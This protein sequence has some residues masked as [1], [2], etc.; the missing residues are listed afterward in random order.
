M[1]RAGYVIVSRPDKTDDSE[2][3][4]LKLDAASYV[5]GDNSVHLRM[6]EG[7]AVDVKSDE[8]V[9]LADLSLLSDT[10][11]TEQQPWASYRVVAF[12]ELN[13]QLAKCYSVVLSLAKKMIFL[14]CGQVSIG[15]SEMLDMHS[16]FVNIYT[17]TH[18]TN[19]L[20]LD[21]HDADYQKFHA[22]NEI[23]Y[24]LNINQPLNI[25]AET[26]RIY[27]AIVA[28]KISGFVL[29]P[30]DE[31]NQWKFNNYLFEVT[32]PQ[33]A[34]GYV[35]FISCPDD[36]YVI[37]QK[38][39]AKDALERI[40]LRTKGVRLNGKTM[41]EVLHERF[42][43]YTFIAHSPFSR[44]RYDVNIESLETGNIYSIM[45]DHCRL[46]DDVTYELRQ[47]EIEYLKSRSVL[48]LHDVNEEL[49]KLYE[50]TKKHLRVCDI[51]YEETFYSK[52]TYLKD[53]K[54]S[55]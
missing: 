41:L 14:K 23:E 30:Q 16:T 32:S 52:L 6:G 40:E 7:H 25:W 37:K 28:E 48:L 49:D 5:S 19:R 18:S 45:F 39:Y 42:P 26:K 2:Y 4:V 43:D 27:S 54:H 29:Q 15:E 8:T 51:T 46:L 1:S 50:F 55:V 3:A 38:I 12:V 22:D 21:N 36:T 17:E 33:E 44:E 34:V 9:S 53:Y 10:T 31:F 24:K 13:G 35:S 11:A 47:C 20:A